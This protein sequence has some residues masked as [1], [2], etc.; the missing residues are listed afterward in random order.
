MANTLLARVHAQASFIIELGWRCGRRQW[1]AEN[2]ITRM[3]KA[4]A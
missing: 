3:Q 4:G 2:K 1:D